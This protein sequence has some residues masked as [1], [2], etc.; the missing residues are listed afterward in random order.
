MK[1]SFVIPCYGSDKTIL[2]V[3]DEVIETV[4][5]LG[6]YDYEIILS[7]DA[8][9]DN[10]WTVIQGLCEQNHKIKGIKLAKNFGQHSV[11]LAGDSQCM[12][13][14]A[15]SFDD[16]GQSSIDELPLFIDK[17][18]ESYDVVYGI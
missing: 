4:E 3:V 6:S 10:V 1:I 5:K 13:D 11:L 16:D 12:G 14:L 9:P 8:S 15:I 2:M 7:E 18:N 17:L